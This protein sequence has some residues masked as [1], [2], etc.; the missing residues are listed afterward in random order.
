VDQVEQVAEFFNITHNTDGPD[1]FRFY[2]YANWWLSNSTMTLSIPKFESKDTLDL[3]VGMVEW[4][5]TVN[6]GDRGLEVFP[7]KAL[8][9]GEAPVC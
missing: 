9:P 5:K 8:P 4:F 3:T 2:H 7:V 1:V 6:F